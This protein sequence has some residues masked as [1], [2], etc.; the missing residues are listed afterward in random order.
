VRYMGGRFTSLKEEFAVSGV[1]SLMMIT[2][3]VYSCKL[4]YYFELTADKM[5]IR[6]ILIKL[7]LTSL[8]IDI[9]KLVLL[10]RMSPISF[11]AFRS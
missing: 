3:M 8:G 7:L 1:S 10:N 4:C 5:L 9:I 11:H 6:C 2:S